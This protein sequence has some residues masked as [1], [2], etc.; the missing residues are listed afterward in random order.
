MSTLILVDLKPQLIFCRRS[1]QCRPKNARQNC[2]STIK[3]SA[4]YHVL[5][6][7]ETRLVNIFSAH[8]VLELETPVLDNEQAS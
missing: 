1:L 5:R 8:A 4:L 7:K 3:M 6:N 2:V